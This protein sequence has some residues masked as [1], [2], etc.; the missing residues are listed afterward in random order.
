MNAE[1]VIISKTFLQHFI[2]QRMMMT[3]QEAPDEPIRN[4]LSRL[5]SLYGLFALHKQLS[6]FY[7]GGYITDEATA[8][9]IQD[10]LMKLC[11]ELKQDAVALVD[12]VAPPDFLLNSFLG[13][14]NGLVSNNRFEKIA[15]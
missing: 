12:V 6:T 7:Q 9:L 2:L 4:V 13:A 11:A 5:L 1:I 8:I 14:S 10:A 15:M 3:I